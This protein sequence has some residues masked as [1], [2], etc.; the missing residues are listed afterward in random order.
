MGAIFRPLVSAVPAAKMLFVMLG[1][2]VDGGAEFAL[3]P[4][5]NP[6]PVLAPKLN[7]PLDPKPLVLCAFAVPVVFAPN[8]NPP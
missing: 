4:N 3:L 2:A 7:P 1:L 8:A 5:A 6:P